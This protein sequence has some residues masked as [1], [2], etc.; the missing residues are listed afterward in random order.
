MA[1]AASSMSMPTS[2]AS[3]PAELRGLE[4]PM[5]ATAGRRS[6]PSMNPRRALFRQTAALKA[7]KSWLKAMVRGESL[8]PAASS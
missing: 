1:A 7:M 8:K 3:R 2:E 4:M 6:R 5:T